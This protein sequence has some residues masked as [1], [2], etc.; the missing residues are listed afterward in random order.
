M[1]KLNGSIIRNILA[2]HTDQDPD[3]LVVLGGL[4]L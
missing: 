2:K 4:V 1:Q 3:L